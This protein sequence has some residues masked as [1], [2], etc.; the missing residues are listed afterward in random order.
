MLQARLNLLNS[1]QFDESDLMGKGMEL[2]QMEA[3]ITGERI[4][5]RKMRDS[6]RRLFGEMEKRSKMQRRSIVWA[7]GQR[8]STPSRRSSPHRDGT[9]PLQ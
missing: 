4:D 7:T 6:A 5:E 1:I 3:K 2:L 9:N 8:T